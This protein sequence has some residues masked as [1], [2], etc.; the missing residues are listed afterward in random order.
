MRVQ[1]PECFVSNPRVAT[2]FVRFGFFVRKSDFRKIRRFRC[3]VCQKTFSNATWN[4]CFRQKKRH[5]NTKIKEFLCSAVSQR[6]TARL[7]KISRTT[8]ARK[9]TFL[10]ERCRASLA[11]MNF[12]NP[13]C[14]SIE[15]DDL[16]TS[17]HTKCKPL[18]VTLA[19]ETGTRRILGFEVSQMPAKGKLA[20]FSRM[21]YGYRRD[22]RP[23]AR[24]RLFRHIFPL[25][26]PNAL[27]KSDESPHYPRD[28]NRFFSHCTHQRFKGKR[29]CVVGQGELKKVGFD[30]LFTLN[31]TYGMLRA[32]INRLA[33]RTWCTTK[34]AEYLADHIA[35][36]AVYHNK[37]LLGL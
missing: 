36:Y 6:R 10:G 33:R 3:R 7:L 12:Q 9:L 8:V 19:V 18:S 11:E 4:D 28:V 34:K 37:V 21:K 1:C 30:P 17:E 16:E 22:E 26:L 14:V 20:Q 25:V 23:E 24:Q 29:G 32:N 13:L 27:I 5:L 15:F 35:I 2:N 31:H